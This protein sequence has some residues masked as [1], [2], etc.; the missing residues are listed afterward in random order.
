MSNIIITHVQFLDIQ[1]FQTSCN[2]NLTIYIFWIDYA[3]NQPV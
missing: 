2:Q 3:R 1:N